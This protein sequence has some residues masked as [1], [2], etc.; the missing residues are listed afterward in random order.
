[1]TVG[2][3]TGFH[4]KA[5]RKL[6]RGGKGKA[7]YP[8]QGGMLHQI[9]MQVRHMGQMLIQFDAPELALLNGIKDAWDPE[10]LLNPGKGVPTLKRCQEYRSL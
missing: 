6:T 7:Q 9:A 5:P 1:M 3:Q 4:V 10:G 8:N 2:R